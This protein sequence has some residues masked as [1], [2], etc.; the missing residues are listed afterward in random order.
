MGKK[1][2]LISLYEDNDETIYFSFSDDKNFYRANI[3]TKELFNLIRKYLQTT[4]KEK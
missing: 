1:I 2:N 3:P 4:P